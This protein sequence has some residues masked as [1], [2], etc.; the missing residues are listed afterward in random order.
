L[1]GNH[2]GWKY[3]DGRRA[4]SR[5]AMVKHDAADI[6]RLA[7]GDKADG[8]HHRKLPWSFCERRFR[9]IRFWRRP[10][11]AVSPGYGESWNRVPLLCHVD[12]VFLRILV[13]VHFE[14]HRPRGFVALPRVRSDQYGI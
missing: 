10:Y 5:H 7:M 8:G 12:F 4:Y 3:L 6:R 13:R 2:P 14:E 1:P 11:Q 9:P